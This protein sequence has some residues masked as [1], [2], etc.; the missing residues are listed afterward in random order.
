MSNQPELIQSGSNTGPLVITK[1]YVANVKFM[2]A[3]Q[4]GTIKLNLL[5]D[6]ATANSTEIHDVLAVPGLSKNLLSVSALLREG[7]SVAFYPNYE[8]CC[9]TKN[10]E[11][12][13][14][15]FMKDNLWVLATE[16]E[17]MSPNS[18]SAM[19][20][21]T[22]SS[23][24]LN[25]NPYCGPA[26]TFL[27][28]SSPM[29]ASPAKRISSPIGPRVAATQTPPRRRA[30]VVGPT[31]KYF[32]SQGTL[33]NRSIFSDR[34]ITTPIQNTGSASTCSLFI[35]SRPCTPNQEKGIPR[36]QAAIQNPVTIS[37]FFEILTSI[38]EPSD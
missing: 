3:T 17:H 14:V 30:T 33:K 16:S 36:K 20:L 23:R 9:L 2:E 38:F 15:G 31:T 34:S 22:T 28:I 32:V 7:I 8:R 6:G 4:K 24:N 26:Y 18:T 5:L 19:T 12:W 10:G 21:F 11:L 1:V 29:A 35:P 13:G 27:G 25:Q 37:N